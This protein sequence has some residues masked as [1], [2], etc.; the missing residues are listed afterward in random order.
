MTKHPADYE[1]SDDHRDMQEWLNIDYRDCVFQILR[2]I[3]TLRGKSHF[4]DSVSEARRLFN[5]AL[6]DELVAEIASHEIRTAREQ[7][8]FADHHDAMW[9]CD[10]DKA[11]ALRRGD[12]AVRKALANVARANLRPV[13][14]NPATGAA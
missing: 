9:Q 5:E 6:V 1:I 4:T 14:T 12:D 3:D 2:A 10:L 11:N 13:T 7:L 8:R